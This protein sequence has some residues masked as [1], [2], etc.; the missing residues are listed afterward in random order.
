[1]EWAVLVIGIVFLLLAYI[2]IQGSRAAMAW[3]KAA[4]AGDVDVIR[5]LVE[6][7]IDAWRSMRRPKDVAPDVW[8]GIQSIELTE[9]EGD[10]IRV[11]CQAESAYRL[12]G[13]RWVETA[14]PLQEGMAITARA[15]DML[16]YELPHVSLRRVQIDV[17]TTFR[18]PD[19][20][21]RRE[22]ILSTPANREVAH[23]VDWENWTAA[24]IVEA[25][26]GRYRLADSGQ[27]LPIDPEKTAASLKP[28]RDARKTR[29]GP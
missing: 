15:A 29:V 10:V 23:Q 2:V 17:Y 12:L 9:V 3:R 5:R 16:M 26:G 25:F 4:A 8:R 27:P 11:S 14:N 7:A 21:T 22:C 28:R 24:E 13:G 6:D 20:T 19:G 1:M 18:A